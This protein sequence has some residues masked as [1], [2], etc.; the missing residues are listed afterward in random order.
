MSRSAPRR[1]LTMGRSLTTWHHKQ[2]GT[3]PATG[4]RPSLILVE[5]HVVPPLPT[6]KGGLWRIGRL[7]RTLFPAETLVRGPLVR[8]MRTFLHEKPHHAA[9]PATS[10]PRL[11]GSFRPRYPRRQ[12]DPP[13]HDLV[14]RP[15]R[16]KSIKL[17][18][19]DQA[20]DLARGRTPS[21]L[22]NSGHETSGREES[23]RV[24][25]RFPSPQ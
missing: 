6:R 11:P 12:I 20:K 4:G 19:L 16:R 17:D 18:H 25:S 7:R 2:P 1:P 23:R 14:S 8:L 10:L 3:G 13:G 22:R 5:K 15:G 21:D 24:E 9:A